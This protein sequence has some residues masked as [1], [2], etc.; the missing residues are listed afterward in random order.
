MKKKLIFISDLGC[1]KRDFERFGIK[2]L[3][4]K[5][6]VLF[7]DC[8]K[9]LQ[10]EFYIR[11]KEID[12]N[13]K[14][15][16]VI[17]NFK[18]LKKTIDKNNQKIVGVIDIFGVSSLHTKIRTYLKNKEIKIIDI[19]N[20]NIK[21]KLNKFQRL[22]SYLYKKDKLKILYRK[23]FLPLKQNHNLGLADIVLINGDA[24]VELTSPKQKK[25]HLCHFDYDIYLKYKKKRNFR[26]N[27]KFAVFLDQF[28]PFHS[29][30]NYI[31][32]ASKNIDHK[33]Y[34]RN[35]EL[36]FQ[37]FEKEYNMEVKIAAHPRSNYKKNKFIKKGRKVFINKTAELV[38]N[39][40]I[41]FTHHSL[42]MN[43]AVLFK[44]PIFFLTFS[45]YK[46]V[47]AFKPNLLSKFFKTYC[48]NMDAKK[49]NFPKKSKLFKIDN[50]SYSK[51][52][53][54][55]LISSKYK[56]LGFWREFSKK[57]QK[58]VII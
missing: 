54:N 34:Y 27:K 46:K 10:F 21:F 16:K 30:Q 23:L 3:R 53:K 29:G 32:T 51:Y 15:R 9:W 40:S 20:L 13:F 43:F 52:K 36:F 7:L 25:I 44:K 5:F 57:I 28:L 42:G 6:D 58:S 41:T 45:S 49:I 48:F 24:G 1:P 2:F 56:G 18:H 35:L 55:Y 39:S 17:K 47:E 22:I 19:L 8:T 14:E 4:S 12:F 37:K 33:T 38:K 26:K 50:D 31:G 11:K